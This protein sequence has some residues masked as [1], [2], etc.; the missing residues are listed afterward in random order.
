MGVTAVMTTQARPGK[1][2]RVRDG[3]KEL[4][5]IIE[6]EGVS[7]RLIRP[8]TGDQQGH[9]SL[10]SEYDSWA[11]FAAAA[12]KIQ[13]SSAYRELMDRATKV[14]EPAVESMTTNFYTD[15]D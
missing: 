14:E 13:E 11:A 15:I 8:V 10:V 1:Y 6:K 7:A 9:L 3:V 4:K 12:D 5:Q 2:D